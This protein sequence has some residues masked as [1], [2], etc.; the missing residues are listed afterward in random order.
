MPVNVRRRPKPLVLVVPAD[1]NAPPPPELAGVGHN[2]GP[3]LEPDLIDACEADPV[4]A[5]EPDLCLDTAL[6]SGEVSFGKLLREIRVELGISQREAAEMSG[7]SRGSIRKIET[8]D[9][10]GNIRTINRLAKCFGYEL[11]LIAVAPPERKRR[12][13]GGKKAAAKSG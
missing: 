11:D 5:S 7:V 13:V 9:R 4:E 12:P 3:S 6:S 1:P 8:E 2:G 10:E